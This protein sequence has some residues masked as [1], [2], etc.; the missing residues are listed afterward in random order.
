MADT[1]N[2]TNRIARTLFIIGGVILFI[3]LVIFIIRLVPMI[4]S[5]VAHVGSSFGNSSKNE[6]T[7]IVT[8]DK[9]VIENEEST[10]VS[11]EYTPETEGQYFVSYSCID[12]LFFDIQSSNGPQRIICD[13][14]F[15]LGSNI[16]A[17]SLIPVL[18]QPNSFIDSTLKIEYKD[19]RNNSLAHGTKLVTINSTATASTNTTTEPTTTNQFDANN[20]LAVSTVTSSPAPT[21]TT[22]TQTPSTPTVSVQPNR[23][24]A[25]T[26]IF[27]LANQSAFTFY[28]YNYG[29]TATGPWTFTYTDAEN[30]SQTLLSPVQAS[31]APGQGLAVTVRFDYQ[32]NSSQ[33]IVV[34][35][36]PT[37]QIP[38]TN[39]T[40]NTGT[41]TIAGPTSSNTG[42]WYNSDDRADLTISSMEVG[43]VSNGRFVATS[44]IYDSDR[45]AIRFTVFNQ[46]GTRTGTWRF[47]VDD[48]PYNSS[49]RTYSSPS[50]SSLAPGEYRDV[51][52]EF[53]GIITGRFN[54]EVFVDS[55]NDVREEQ[56]NNNK[57]SRR[58]TVR[59]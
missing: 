33:T 18:T 3:V 46:G 14:P 1:T 35:V 17:I 49:Q 39:R 7:I 21:T 11:F 40:N 15:R 9:E 48:L 26:Q 38:E 16:N 50:Q 56:E 51:L 44:S 2:K 34:M 30:P 28:T 13:T 43:R 42:G 29:N 12:G 27:P 25:L 36:N 41:V 53:D 54:P 47:E 19:A 23:D 20:T 32:V 8:T 59:N 10:L 45:G 24:F 57:E 31:L 52:V 6:E 5:G 58:L 55:R 22:N 37:N 4:V